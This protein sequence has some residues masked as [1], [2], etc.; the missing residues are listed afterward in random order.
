MPLVSTRRP[1]MIRP[2]ATDCYF[3]RF[4]QLLYCSLLLFFFLRRRSFYDSPALR[5][6]SV[7]LSHA[8]GALTLPLCPRRIDTRAL[9]RATPPAHFLASSSSPLPR[10][11]RRQRLNLKISTDVIRFE[12]RKRKEEEIDLYPLITRSSSRFFSLA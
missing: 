11:R 4:F 10:G 9:P 5:C 7:R 6:L 8:L 1:G 2:G 12:I 3:V